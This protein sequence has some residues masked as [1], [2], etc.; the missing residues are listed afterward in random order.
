MAE[1]EKTPDSIRFVYKKG[2]HHRT[3]HSDG[4][5]A[6]VSPKL[7]VQF[8]F[9]NDLRPLPNATTHRVTDDGNLGEE[10]SRQVSENIE[11]ETDVT[12]VMQK[13]AVESLIDVL[14]R[15]VKQIDAHID[16]A[17]GTAPVEQKVPEISEA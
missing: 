7:E 17:K 13:D 10:V 8:S 12:V 4:A 3:F 16:K 2:R 6:S 14:T 5:W 15:M 1:E 9:F 11:R